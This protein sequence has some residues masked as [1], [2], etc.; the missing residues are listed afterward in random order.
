M[1]NKDELLED[2]REDTVVN[3]IP[4]KGKSVAIPAHPPIANSHDLDSHVHGGR[5]RRG[6]C[7]RILCPVTR[8]RLIM[9][10]LRIR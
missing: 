7:T 4:E 8:H 1:Q 6:V 2:I 10:A 9:H 5:R 3:A